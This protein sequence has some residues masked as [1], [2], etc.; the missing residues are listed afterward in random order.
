MDITI[1]KVKEPG[2]W[3]SNMSPHPIQYE[4]R[5]FRTC[6]A[7]FQWLRFHKHPEV[8]DVIIDQISPMG[9]KMKARLNRNLLDR[10]EKW[11]E[12]EEDIPWMKTCLRLKIE[13]HPALKNLLLETGTATIIEDCTT[14]DRESSRFWGAV[15]INGKWVGKNILGKLWMELRDKLNASTLSESGNP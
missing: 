11:D 8:Q 13:Q 5:N 7:L 2:G 1:T 4:G 6:E 14:H 3:L 10:S 15:K 9:A 12:A